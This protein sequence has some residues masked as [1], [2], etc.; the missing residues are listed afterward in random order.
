MILD[1]FLYYSK[2]ELIKLCCRWDTNLRQKWCY[3]RM[4]AMLV[5]AERSWSSLC[6]AYP[7]S[8]IS[9]VA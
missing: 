3:L 5:F 4:Q 6:H 2:F 9:P 8:Y 7:V 1:T